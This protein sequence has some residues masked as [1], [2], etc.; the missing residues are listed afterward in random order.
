MNQLHHMPPP[1]SQGTPPNV[2]HWTRRGLPL[3]RDFYAYC[4][5][6]TGEPFSS[7]VKKKIIGLLIVLFFLL[8]TVWTSFF[9]SW[10]HLCSCGMSK[11]DVIMWTDVKN[12]FVLKIKDFCCVLYNLPLVFLRVRSSDRLRCGGDGFAQEYVRHLL[13]WWTGMNEVVAFFKISNLL[14]RLVAS[15]VL[16]VQRSAVW[17]PREPRRILGWLC[18][19]RECARYFFHH[20]FPF[21]CFFELLPISGRWTSRRSKSGKLFQSR[22]VFALNDN[23]FFDWT[24]APCA[25][26][27]FG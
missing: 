20:F 4:C 26:V 23:F 6:K 21:I 5:P 1:G 10:N 16:R 7:R 24:N 9:S 13:V 18:D 19:T 17:S 12:S 27:N 2:G 22:A 11:F 3:F 14:V 25:Y 15:L 8:Q